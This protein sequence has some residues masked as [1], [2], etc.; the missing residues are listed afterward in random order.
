M[1]AFR[2]DLMAMQDLIA[3]PAT[4]LF[5]PPA[6]GDGQTALRETLLVADH[7]A[8]QLGQLIIVRRLQGAWKDEK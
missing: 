6:H 3:N 8:Y 7:N 4:D 1:A 5:T 2:A